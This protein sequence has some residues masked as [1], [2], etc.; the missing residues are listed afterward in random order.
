MDMLRRTIYLDCHANTSPS[1]AVIE[2]IRDTMRYAGNPNADHAAGR[3]AREVLEEARHCVGTA[4]QVQPQSIFFT[5][6]ASESINL[7]LRSVIE[8]K[9][10]ER[11]PGI[12]VVS[13]GIEHSAVLETLRDCVGRGLCAIRLVPVD[14]R[15]IARPEDVDA[16]VDDRTVLVT[17]Q[18]ANNEVGTIQ[19]VAEIAEIARR[20]DALLHADLCQS[21][22]K[23]PFGP[24][25]DLAS[26]SAHKLH[27]PM[28]VG[29][30]YVSDRARPYL[31]PQIRG[32]SQ[33]GGLRAGTQNV[34]GVAGFGV[35]CREQAARWSDPAG[36]S[37][38]GLS[39][40]A[41]RLAWLRDALARALVDA[42]GAEQVRVNGAIDPAVWEPQVTADPT[43][44]L[45]LPHN[46]NVTFRGV[47]PDALKAALGDRIA[48]TTAAACKSG[49]RSHVLAAMGVPDDGATVRLGLGRDNTEAEVREAAQILVDAAASLQG[50][51]CPI[52]LRKAAA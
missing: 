12:N 22:G 15:G 43:R 26:I 1:E 3:R 47:C 28:G 13:S 5:S 6:G 18:G 20:R 19:P 44:R 35:A 24:V 29:A 48:V 11:G 34:Q 31:T 30:L 27:G 38:G 40:E 52:H 7:S 9:L 37:V 33:E 10:R 17:V 21:F 32:G 2:K 25:F 8:G 16:R 50:Q 46:L 41:L 4:L 51:G 49:K 36:R 39:G 14:A 23:V 45:R 42:L